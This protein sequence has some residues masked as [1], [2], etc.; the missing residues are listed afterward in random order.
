MKRK[1][2]AAVAAVAMTMPCITAYANENPEME[3]GLTLVADGSK[4]YDT[5]E[6]KAGEDITFTAKTNEFKKNGDNGFEAATL[7][8]KFDSTSEL[9]SKPDDIDNFEFTVKSVKFNGEDVTSD[10]TAY[11]LTDMKDGGFNLNKSIDDKGWANADGDLIAVTEVEV[12]I[13]VTVLDS[14]NKEKESDPESSQTEESSEKAED[15]ESSTPD[16]TPSND[17]SNAIAGGS[18]SFG[19]GFATIA[20]VAAGITAAKRKQ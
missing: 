10:E 13:N 17:D 5:K 2:L 8:F 18:G 6:I 3:F 9:F 16:K 20:I 7:E 14:K 19:I 15:A 11:T 1:L 12:V 4:V